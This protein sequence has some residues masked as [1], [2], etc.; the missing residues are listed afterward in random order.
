MRILIDI[1]HPG[2]VHLFRPFAKI[3]QNK[4]HKI[5]FTCRQKEFEIELL[6]YYK[7]IFHSFGKKYNTTIG[8]IFGLLLFNTKMLLVSLKFKP[9]IYL[10]HGSMYAA[11]IAFLLRKP[12]VSFEDTFNFEQ[13]HLYKPFTSVILSSNYKH[14]D[15]GKNNIKYNGYHELAYLHPKRFE[16]NPTVIKELGLKD[17][18]K[19]CILRFVSWEATHDINHKGISIENKRLIVDKLSK[20]LKV[21]I[22]SEKQLPENLEKYKF[23]LPPESMHEAL[24]FASLVYGESATMIAEG[25]MLGVP[26]VYL[27]NTGRLYTK[28]LENDYGLVFNYSESELDQTKSINKALEFVSLNETEEWKKKQSHMLSDKIDVTAFLVWF[29]ENYPQSVRIMKE[30]PNYQYRFK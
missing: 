2:H 29:V 15:L 28:E 16:P 30:N 11:H 17:G 10:S 18:E 24:A 26:G 3:M 20:H 23:P 9:D 27:D 13:I 21:F 7:L 12:H 22:S 5:L 14:P 25:A 1:G 19:Y 8:K 4:G 6:K